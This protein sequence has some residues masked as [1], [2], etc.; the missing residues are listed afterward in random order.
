MKIFLCHNFWFC[1]VI[2]ICVPMTHSKGGNAIKVNHNCQKQTKLILTIFSLK[3]SYMLKLVI[4]TSSYVCNNENFCNIK[5]LRMIAFRNRYRSHFLPNFTQLICMP[6]SGNHIGYVCVHV[7]ITLAACDHI[8]VKQMA[9]FPNLN[10]N[11][12]KWKLPK[13]YT[14]FIA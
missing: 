7:W 1:I 4:I 9:I 11:Q 13:V 6:L 8:R 14:L 10:L 2:T 12:H 3:K 5:G